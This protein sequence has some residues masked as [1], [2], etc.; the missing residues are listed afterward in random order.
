MLWAEQA[1]LPGGVE[2]AVR[3]DVAADGTIAGVTPNARSTGT[4]LPGIVM[5]GFANVHSHAFHRALRG[6]THSGRGSFWTWREQ[7]Y[8]A[9]GH[10]TPDNYHSLAT[11]VYAEMALAGITCVGEFHYVHHDRDGQPYRN[12]HAMDDA[13]RAAARA[14]GVRL[15]LLD[16]CYLSSGFGRSL[17]GVQLRFGDGDAASWANRFEATKPDDNTRIGAAIHSVRA[18]P[19]E[20]LPVIVDAA[21]GRPLHVHLSEQPAENDECLATYA[22]TPT[23]LLHDHG[24]LSPMTTAVHAT[25]LTADDIA[26][27]GAAGATSAFCPTTERDLADGI[28][29]AR[30]LADAGCRLALGTDQHAMIDMFEEARAVEL[31]ERLVTQE[32]GR[33]RPEELVH[34]M[35][36]AGHAALGWPEAGQIRAGAP[37]DLVAV[38]LDTVRTAGSEPGQIVM[39]AGAPDVDTVVV[40]GRAVVRGGQ[41]ELG[42]VGRLIADAVQPIV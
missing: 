34:A 21:Q 42:D 28:G 31:H 36:E 16:T 12:P 24:V 6:R 39:T 15:T 7:M 14:A 17:A 1:W 5:P 11:A 33:F 40:G 8:A 26:M 18:V 32:R 2:S 3:I 10:L 22:A 27:L 30:A 9:A 20:Q 37:A 25:H 19:P 35:S 29:P 4:T 13:L 23:Q 41:H 38:R